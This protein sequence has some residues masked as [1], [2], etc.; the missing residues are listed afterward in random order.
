MRLLVVGLAHF[1][2]Q[3]Q[4]PGG[5]LHLPAREARFVFGLRQAVLQPTV[6]LIVLALNDDGDVGGLTQERAERTLNGLDVLAGVALEHLVEATLAQQRLHG[7]FVAYGSEL[8]EHQRDDRLPVSPL[9][10]CFGGQ[11]VDCQ[12]R[13]VLALVP[14]SEQSEGHQSSSLGGIDYQQNI[15]FIK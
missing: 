3:K 10:M 6:E 13:P 15:I 8:R 9:T 14:M 5:S 12:R 4:R 1:D 2:R 11:Q 7:C